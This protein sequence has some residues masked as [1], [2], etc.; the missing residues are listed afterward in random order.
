MERR[1]TV[2]GT[3][4][5][6]V[7]PDL[8]V[9]DLRLESLDMDYE[10]AMAQATRSVEELNKV[11]SGVGFKKEDLKTTSFNVTTQYRSEQ[12]KR[13]NY[14]QVFEG[15]LVGHGLLLEFDF[16]QALLTRTL[17]AIATA[18]AMPKLDIRFSIKDKT[19]VSEELLVKA[20]ENAKSKALV[21]AKASG[22]T[23]GQ[24][25]LIDYS[26]ADFHLYSRTSYGLEDA[27]MMKSAALAPDIEPEEI[28]LSD[29]VT[30]VW[31]LL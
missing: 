9:I 15:Y 5:V 31:E 27:M 1:I 29:N 7:K 10:Q 4:Q 24:L 2:K 30:F 18:Q 20:S 16:E 26:W 3:G 8:I 22:A 11:L 21:L 25:V 12:D 17:S 23:L 6:S 13:G 28:S 14:I 19:A